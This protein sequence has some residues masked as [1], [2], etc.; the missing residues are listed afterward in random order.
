M[1]N[2]DDYEDLDDNFIRVI[3][4]GTVIKVSIID[5]IENL[6]DYLKDGISGASLGCKR[7]IDLDKLKRVLK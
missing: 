3:K 5:F 1:M 4:E 6:Q 2:E 7:A